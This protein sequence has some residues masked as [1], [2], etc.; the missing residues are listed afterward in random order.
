MI[1]S[2]LAEFSGSLDL[3][4]QLGHLF[5]GFP[6]KPLFCPFSLSHLHNGTVIMK[7]ILFV[8]LV[9]FP[10]HQ[11]SWH[12]DGH[13]SV[14]FSIFVHSWVLPAEA[15]CCPSLLLIPYFNNHFF[16]KVIVYPS[17][18]WSQKMSW[19]LLVLLCPVDPCC[20]SYSNNRKKG[21]CIIFSANFLL[22]YLL[23]HYLNSTNSTDDCPFGFKVI[24]N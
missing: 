23:G 7:W 19:Y 4:V 9:F 21:R 17:T 3:A 2:F 1:T 20:D 22:Q 14:Q 16:Y 6:K 13:S 15:L 5:S 10:G 12:F 18:Q 11:K 8:L 24:F